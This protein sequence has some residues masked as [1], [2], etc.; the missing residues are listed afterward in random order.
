MGAAWP[1]AGEAATGAELLLRGYPQNA[2]KTEIDRL[3]RLHTG[4]IG[5]LSCS[6]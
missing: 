5:P 2:Q 4:Q 6:D 3:D 1:W